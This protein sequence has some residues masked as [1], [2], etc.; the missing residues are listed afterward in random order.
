MTRRE[1]TLAVAA[2]AAGLAGCLAWGGVRVVT[3]RDGAAAS[4]RALADSE[5]LA[6][7]IEAARGP[8]A[9]GGAREVARRFG[10]AARAA[11]LAEG[12][13]ARVEPGTP[14]RLGDTPFIEHPTAVELRD[15]SLQ[16]LFALL[17]AL[18]ADDAAGGPRVRLRDIRLTAPARDV[19][20]APGDDGAADVWAV[21]GTLTYRAY[22]PP[23]D[24]DAR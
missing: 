2:V 6:R 17:H 9:P 18:A 13:V 4:A 16:Q 8:A 1:R 15:V 21:R 23:E 24:P 11:G 3:A 20:A 19:T 22:V 10:A 12:S 14:A 5:R 7:Q